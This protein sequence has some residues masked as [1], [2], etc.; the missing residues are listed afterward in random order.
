MQ[1]EEIL[2]EM[3]GIRSMR[4]GTITEQYLKVKHAGKEEPVLRGP[5]YVF[6]RREKHKTVAY[7]LTSRQDIEEARRDIAAHQRYAELCGEYERLTEELG[8]LERETPLDDE[9]KKKRKQ[10]GSSKMQK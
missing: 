5:Y 8:Y 9:Q 4:R 3:R 10:S 7:R 1:R 6:S 2:E